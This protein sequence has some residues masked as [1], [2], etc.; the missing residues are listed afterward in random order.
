MHNQRHA[1]YLAAVEFGH[2]GCSAIHMGG[3][4]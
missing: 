2:H 3:A 1:G 4:Y